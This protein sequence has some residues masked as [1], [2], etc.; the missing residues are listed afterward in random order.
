MSRCDQS[1]V[2]ESNEG[3][4]TGRDRSLTGASVPKHGRDG[5]SR[6]RR[7]RHAP[8]LRQRRLQV[9][10]DLGGDD[11][12][13]REVGAILQAFVLQPEDVEI[14][15]VAPGELVVAEALEA[16]GLLALVAGGGRRG[17]L[18]VA[19]PPPRSLKISGWRVDAVEGLA[20]VALLHDVGEPGAGI[21]L[22]RGVFTLV[23]PVLDGFAGE[24]PEAAALALARRRFAVVAC[25]AD[26]RRQRQRR[27][28]RDPDQPFHD[29]FS[30]IKPER[31]P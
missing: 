31:K 17:A 20:E 25:R 22:L 12:R 5:F 24:F 3:I 6:T 23:E 13:G 29:S 7:Q 4:S 30:L 28:E 1:A 26:R 15:A 14:E 9:L 19:H 2:D 27:N 18:G 21:I 10:D 16:A 11:V 8:E